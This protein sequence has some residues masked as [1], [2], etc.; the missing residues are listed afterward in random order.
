MND[1]QADGVTRH[2]EVGME[3]LC[4]DIRQIAEGHSEI[5]HELQEM[6]DEFRDECKE[7]RA[8][9][10]LSFSQLDQGFA[11]SKLICRH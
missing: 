10:R 5:H 11:H 6:R 4:N 9:I 7:M 1:A 2:V 8:L 3:A